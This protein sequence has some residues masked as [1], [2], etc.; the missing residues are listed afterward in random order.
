VAWTATTVTSGEQEAFEADKPILMSYNFLEGYTDAKWTQALAGTWAGITDQA[1]AAY[2]IRRVQD[3]YLH[4][5]TKSTEQNS[6]S[7]ALVFDL[8]ASWEG[9]IDSLAI[10]TQNLKYLADWNSGYVDV[11]VTAS[12]SDPSF[13]GAGGSSGSVLANFRTNTDAPLVEHS[14]T[15]SSQVHSYARVGGF[16]YLLIEFVTAANLVDPFAYGGTAFIV[17]PVVNEVVISGPRGWSG[18]RGQLSRYSD[19]PYAKYGWR[20]N[21]EDFAALSGV[22]S[23]Y[24][25]N[26]GARTWANVFTP[27]GEGTTQLDKF[28]LNDTRTLMDLWTNTNYGTRPFFWGPNPYVS[29]GQFI[30]TSDGIKRRVWNTNTYHVTMEAEALQMVLSGGLYNRDVEI[31]FIE[32]APYLAGILTRS[33]VTANPTW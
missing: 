16:R 31:N 27:S 24:V 11:R 20:S 8:G 32:N 29:Q 26:V 13:T 25:N 21:Y 14:L 18:K 2:P 17:P 5:G 7:Y 3:G 28:G 23:R 15:N 10:Y 9:P 30:T 6:A 19:F 12:E 1:D 4:K 22:T 33:G